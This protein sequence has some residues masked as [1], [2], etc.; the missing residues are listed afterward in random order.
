ML[1]TLI[2]ATATATLAVS[3]GAHEEHRARKTPAAAAGPAAAPG[4]AHADMSTAE[5]AAATA[6]EAAT[7]DSPPELPKTFS[8]RLLRWMGL[9]H[10]SVVHFPIALFIATAFLEGAAL[11]LGKPGLAAGARVSI[12][13]A[14]LTAVP[15]V[16]LGWLNMGFDLAADDAVHRWHRWI[17][18]ALAGL[19]LVA[20]WAK[21]RLERGPGRARALV[22]GL[23][24]AVTV[25]LLVVNGYLGGAIVHG[26]RHL[27]F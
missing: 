21:E 24:L 2:L 15:A 1:L 18:T 17:G 27:S 20:W 25:A 16:G 6:A 10:P 8:G 4:D 11:V 5:H 13:L 22:Y 9:W 26:P 3:A 12:A 23:V 19:A 7:P 14:A